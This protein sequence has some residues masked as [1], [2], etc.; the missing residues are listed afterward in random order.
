MAQQGE[1]GD[2]QHAAGPSLQ[3]PTAAPAEVTKR[4]YAGFGSFMVDRSVEEMI[5]EPESTYQPPAR[6][7][8]LDERCTSLLEGCSSATELGR[9]CRHLFMI[10]FASWTYINHG[11]FGGVCR[12]AHLEANQWREHCEAQPLR[13]LDR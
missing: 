3:Q 10:D 12:P 5:H 1:A 6:P 13:F 7:F 11:A 8:P 9:A 2:Q 4:G